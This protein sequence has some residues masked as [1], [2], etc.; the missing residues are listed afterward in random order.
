MNIFLKRLELQGFKSFAQ[1]TVFE[2]P[3][4]VTAIVGPNGSGKSNV[5]DAFRWVL[6]EREAKQLRG[7]TLDNLI[8]AGTPKRPAASLARVGLYFDN[9]KDVFEQ[10]GKEVMLVRRVDRSGVSQFL[11]HDTEVKLKD[12]L[13]M[14]ARARLG[15]RGLTMVGQGQ[16]DIF[17]KSNPNE[18]RAMIEEVLGLREFRIKKSQ[19][20]RRLINSTI[21]MEKVRAMLE[22]LTPHLRLLRRQRTRWE[23][24][25]EI[26]DTLIEIENRYFGYRYNELTQ[27]QSSISHP[28]GDDGTE[29]ATQEMEIEKL[30]K[31]ITMIDEKARGVTVKHEWREE[32]TKLIVKYCTDGNVAAFGVESFDEEVCKANNLNSRPEL[33]MKA[34]RQINKYGSD[35]GLSGLPKF[36][37]GINIIFGLNKETKNTNDI[38]MKYLKQIV[39]ENLLLRRINI[40]QVTLLADTILTKR[41]R[42]VTILHIINT[43]QKNLFS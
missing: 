25:S 1:K 27:K 12:L 24:R 28:K 11:F 8:F 34:I 23:K 7:D 15:S 18:R 4:R 29:R 32:I 35:R 36:I 26:A 16:S 13:P 33:T 20:E 6:G 37:P 30:E 43:I 9:H 39:D 2:F 31:S 40:R 41:V 14:L 38:N 42:Y 22:E 5:I 17:V 3:A 21:N 19:A 10:A